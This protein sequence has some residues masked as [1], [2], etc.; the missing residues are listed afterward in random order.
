MGV[1]SLTKGRRKVFEAIEASEALGLPLHFHLVGESE[2]VFP[3]VGDGRFTSTGLYTD[4]E[5]PRLIK[6]ARPDLFLF[7]SSAPETYSYTLTAAMGTGIPI[8][9]T[10]LGAFSER[11][12]GYCC[13]QLYPHQSTGAQ[14]A[15]IIHDFVGQPRAR[16]QEAMNGPRK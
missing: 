11:L 6:E 15:G 8:L 13:K 4:D 3:A 2:G 16:H 14:L 1:F 12:E 10:D 9:A 5:L 7:A